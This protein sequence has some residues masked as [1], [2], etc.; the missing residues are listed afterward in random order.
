ML[1]PIR[2][3]L[4]YLLVCT[5]EKPRPAPRDSQK[6][7]KPPVS[8]PMLAFTDHFSQT[9]VTFQHFSIGHIVEING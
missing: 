1:S 6:T 2:V 9:W 3:E 4:T 8:W 7:F 5:Y